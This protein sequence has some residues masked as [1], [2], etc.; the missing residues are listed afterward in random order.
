VEKLKAF[1]KTFNSLTGISGRHNRG[2]RDITGFL[3]EIKGFISNYNLQ[4]E[5]PNF[6]SLLGKIG[7]AKF[8]LTNL[9]Y[10]LRPMVKTAKVIKGVK[11]S[12]IIEEISNELE[13]FRRA[14]MNPALRKSQLKITIAE[15]LESVNNLQ[16]KLSETEYR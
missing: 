10:H 6:K 1:S 16:A 8:D 7:Y 13:D 14:L 5:S 3:T 11:T 9:S 12:P 2:L 15:L 4:E